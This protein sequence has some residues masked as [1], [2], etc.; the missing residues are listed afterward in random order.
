MNYRDLKNNKNKPVETAKKP[1]FKPQKASKT[2]PELKTIAKLNNFLANINFHFLETLAKPQIKNNCCFK[3]FVRRRLPQ[4][5]TL[6]HPLT[7]FATVR[8]HLQPLS[9]ALKTLELN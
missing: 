5:A 4:F 3:H 8:N 9:E 2:N 1:Q 6:C 7:P